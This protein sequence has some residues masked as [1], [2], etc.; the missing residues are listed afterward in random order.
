[1]EKFDKVA[2]SGGKND[3]VLGALIEK[4][5]LKFGKEDLINYLEQQVSCSGKRKSLTM[6]K[7]SGLWA[8]TRKSQSL[9][10]VHPG[11][12]QREL[13][14]YSAPPNCR[15]STGYSSGKNWT[16]EI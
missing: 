1:M 8:V 14:E 16:C 9:R 11:V 10:T 13:Q 2:S 15:A 5:V 6:R 3:E 4:Y 7:D 12:L